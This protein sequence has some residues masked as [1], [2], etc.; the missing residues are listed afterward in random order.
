[1][2]LTACVRLG[3][4]LPDAWTTRMFHRDST[5]LVG[6]SPTQ[7]SSYARMPTAALPACFPAGLPVHCL[8]ALL[9]AGLPAC[10]TQKVKATL[11][12][13]LSHVYWLMLD[14]WYA[15]RV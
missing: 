10:H 6:T 1:M 9:P 15:F 8:R 12:G 3:Q 5:Q 2:A 7:V 14:P 13:S 4:R 11:R